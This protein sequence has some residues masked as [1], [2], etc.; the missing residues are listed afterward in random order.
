MKKIVLM[1]AAAAFGAVLFQGCEEER[2]PVLDT[3]TAPSLTAPA[4]NASIVIEEAMLEETV[5]TIS[6]SAAAFSLET[7]PDVAYQVELTSTNLPTNVTVTAGVTGATTLSLT[8]NQLNGFLLTQMAATPGVPVELEVVVH[9]SL[10]NNVAADDLHSGTVS[11]SA[12]PFEQVII[13]DPIYL[14]GNA[15]PAGW[16]NGQATPMTWVEGGVFAD[17]VQLIAFDSDGDPQYIKFIANLGA[18][19]PQWGTDAAATAESGN[20]VYRPTEAAADPPTIPVPATDGMYI[21]TADTAN[22]TYTI[23]PFVE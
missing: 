20:L 18:W 9:A 23:V 17:T 4:A 21:I 11:I 19:A 22:M 10:V 3:M 14:L 8:G 13:P 6:W 5:L 15:S 12:T 2:G 16:N 1:F 7:L